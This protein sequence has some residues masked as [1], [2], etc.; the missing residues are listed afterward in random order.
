MNITELSDRLADRDVMDTLNSICLDIS[1][2]PPNGARIHKRRSLGGL[3][4][5]HGSEVLDRLGDC[6]FQQLRELSRK[7]Y[8][9][10]IG[11]IRDVVAE[12]IK[13]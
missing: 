13:I 6:T 4:E 11:Y 8:T 12:G 7:D 1:L 5:L 2:L 10:L 9:E 3:I